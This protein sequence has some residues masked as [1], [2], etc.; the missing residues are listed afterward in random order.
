MLR[1]RPPPFG[2][3]LGLLK[4]RRFLRMARTVRVVQPAALAISRSTCDLLRI[5]SRIKSP[6]DFSRCGANF[7]EVIAFD[8]YRRRR[9]E[10]SFRDVRGPCA[11]PQGRA[12]LLKT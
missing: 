2:E 1:F 8:R 7:G 6:F 3:A 4:Q 5:I 9:S 12:G 10:D 11:E